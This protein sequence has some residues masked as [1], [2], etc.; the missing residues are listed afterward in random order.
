ME[1]VI[2]DQKIW[3]EVKDLPIPSKEI[4]KLIGEIIGIK[5]KTRKGDPCDQYVLRARVLGLY[6]CIHSL[7]KQIFLNAGEIWKIGKTCL[8]KK[9][10]YSGGLSD[11]RLTFVREFS[12][13]AEQ[14]LIVEKIKLYAYVFYPENQKRLNPLI[15]PP[16]NKI[17]R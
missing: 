17:H 2:N 9:D 16:G 1:E 12:G 4:D 15:L 14:C 8:E 10:R 6:G 7:N 11:D 5:S 3:Q 13:T